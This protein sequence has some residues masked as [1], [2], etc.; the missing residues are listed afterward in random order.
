MLE[1]IEYTPTA[2]EIQSIIKETTIRGYQ[3]RIQT[4]ST[5][6]T[7][8]VCMERGKG[9]EYEY[10]LGKASRLELEKLIVKLAKEMI[11]L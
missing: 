11:K 4:L 1:E 6:L 7:W 2:E 10:A 3:D 9:I 5:A 8:G